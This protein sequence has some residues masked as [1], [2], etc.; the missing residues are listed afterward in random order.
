MERF[1]LGLVLALATFAP[2]IARA[3]TGSSDA[4]ETSDD[5]DLDDP[6]E[7][8]IDDDAAAALGVSFATPLV[9]GA[10]SVGLAESLD[11]G[12]PA[13]ALGLA[14]LLLTSAIAPGIAWLAVG[15][16][17]AG[18]ASLGLNLGALALGAGVGLWA[19]S[20]LGEPLGASA[21]RGM[22]WSAIVGMS[23]MSIAS[24]TQTT[25]SDRGIRMDARSRARALAMSS[26]I[27]GSLAGG[28]AATVFASAD[29]GPRWSEIGIGLAV[30]GLSPAL[31]W[32]SLGDWENSGLSLLASAAAIGLAALVGAIAA[33]LVEVEDPSA[34]F[35]ES[36]AA[37]LALGTAVYVPISAILHAALSGGAGPLA[38][39]PRDEEDL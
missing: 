32:A 33:P 19:G 34:T 13:V 16:E 18:W 9:L 27:L 4:S 6:P 8:E 39:P 17:R 29:G 38:A 2:P 25:G 10:I 20:A 28:A 21:M 12:D 23:F 5:P 35:E 14:P 36:F 3:E 31:G 26:G 30:A 1:A 37:G 15:E 22:A 24:W 11:A 7:L